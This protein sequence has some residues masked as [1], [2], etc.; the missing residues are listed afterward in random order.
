VR[1]PPSKAG[2][3]PACQ[4]STDSVHCGARLGQ[5]SA[6]GCARFSRQMPESPPAAANRSIGRSAPTKPMPPR[7]ASGLSS[8]FRKV[9]FRCHAQVPSHCGRPNAI[10]ETVPA[11]PGTRSAARTVPRP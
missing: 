4:S 2:R 8:N 7:S 1:T 5:R 9:Q 3:R 10:T 11:G 6:Q